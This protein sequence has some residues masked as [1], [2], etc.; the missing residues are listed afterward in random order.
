MDIS[1]GT[2]VTRLLVNRDRVT[3]V[4]TEKTSY[5]AAIVVNCA[6]HGRDASVLSAFR[7]DR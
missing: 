5:S 4:Q 3:G 6:G 1:S 2:E 7:Y